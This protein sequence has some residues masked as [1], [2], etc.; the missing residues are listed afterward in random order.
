MNSEIKAA[1]L[2]EQNA[3]LM[4]EL[5]KCAADLSHM[6]E[7]FLNEQ[8]RGNG[9]EQKCIR[10]E[11]QNAVLVS[12]LEKIADYCGDHAQ[13]VAEEALEKVRGE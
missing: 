12:A 4:K 2:K 8:S 5:L 6:E 3:A 11:E 13:V 9:F 7:N 1:I 10:F